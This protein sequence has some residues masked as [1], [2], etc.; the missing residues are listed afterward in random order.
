MEPT[1]QEGEQE[2]RLEGNKSLTESSRTP[3]FNLRAIT[4]R[5]Q[6][7]RYLWIMMLIIAACFSAKSQ[8]QQYYL[9]DCTGTNPSDFPSINAALAAGPGPN[10]VILVT[11][12]CTENVYITSAFN[13][14]IGAW[15]G[16]TAN[17]VGGISVTD[18]ESVYFYGLNVSNPTGSGFNI[19][20]SRAVTL[21]SCTSNGNLGHGLEESLQSEVSLNTMG[22]F[23]NNSA[24]GVYLSSASLFSI[25]S[26]G[27]PTDISN[28]VGQGV[29]LSMNS[30]FL[31]GGN[32][33]INNNAVPI[34]SS[35]TSPVFGVTALGHTTVQFGGC[36]GP[37]TIQ[38]N[39]AGGF[40]M[41]EDSELSIFDCGTSYQNNVLANGPVGISAGF[42][43]QV[44]LYKMATISGHTAGGVELYG[45]SQLNVEGGVVISNNGA[46]GQS[47]S[48]GVVVDGNSEAYFRGGQLNTNHG[49]GLLVLVNSS[50][51][52][53]GT[54]FSGNT[55]G[56]ISCD[57]SAFMVTDELVAT[58][59]AACPIPHHLGNRRS[60]LSAP[61]APD[62]TALKVKHAR[63]AKL[64]SGK[65]H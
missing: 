20:S 4:I 44:T 11:G 52:F 28:N 26:W 9:V 23:D 22:S 12:T 24:S 54:T 29:W 55:A 57:S 41:E 10:S 50:A 33:S 36:E 58:E 27:G 45:N 14:N 42:G 64:A 31:A 63:Y 51:D 48:A 7:G 35:T 65:P 60:S 37:N 53:T 17:L 49:P 25:N 34:N 21:D 2:V 43:S 1:I 61:K 19:T 16:Q 3:E 6:K 59:G 32:T 56:P 18:S 40:D 30:V 8:A 62:L 38:G 39:Q 47:R 15:Y 13:L 5:R 46:A